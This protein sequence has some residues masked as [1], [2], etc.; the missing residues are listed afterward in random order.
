MSIEQSVTK[1]K[2]DSLH[3][4]A[5]Q[6]S[7]F[8]Q[9]SAENGKALHEMEPLIHAMVLKM[10]FAAMEQFL[11]LQGNGDVGET[12]QTPQGKTLMRSEVPLARELRTIF[13]THVIRSFGYSAGAKKAIELRPVEAK[14]ALSK[15]HFSYYYEQFA[16]YFNVDQA[17][18]QATRGL[19]MVLGSK[20]SIDSLEHLNRRV[21]EQAEA[22]LETL[23]TPPPKEE[24]QLL[25]LSADG[26]G[27]PLVQ[28]DAAKFAACEEKP[29]RP[30]NRRMATVAAVYTVDPFVR[31]PEEIVAALFR[32][33]PPNPASKT[34]RPEPQFKHVA[35]FFAKEYDDGE[36]TIMSTGPIEAFTWANGQIE[37]RRTEHQKLIRLMDGQPSLWTTADEIVNVP[38]TETVD[39]LDILHANS[40]VWRAAK[41]FH[42]HK[43]HQEAFTQERLL[44]ILQGDVRGVIAGLRQMGT[45]HKLNGAAK[46]ELATV[47]NYLENNAD[48]MRYHKYLAKGYPIATGVIEGACRHLVKD[49]MER[50][51]MR[52]TLAGA[53]NMLHVRAVFQS[54]YWEQFQAER[55][56]REQAP[57]HAGYQAAHS[58]N[59]SNLAI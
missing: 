2:L 25:V 28:A 22:F 56:A 44:R 18:R 12:Y 33:D 41:V 53:R 37:S 55:I 59:L 50:S 49:R 54:S 6:L 10:G 26:K 24:G 48:R 7:A 4:L 17:F 16:Q 8:V 46:K 19:E 5:D 34:K 1:C 30:G 9:Q 51:G 23:P 29:Q 14:L 42:A 3:S 57:L 36:E 58:S 20:V 27:V 13:G 35:A 38:E 45:K 47:C 21:G 11:T 32:E 39:I 52:W 40:Y 31:T 43:E 15:N